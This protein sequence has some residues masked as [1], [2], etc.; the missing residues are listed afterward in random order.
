MRGSA[1]SWSSPA[2]PAKNEYASMNRSAIMSGSA[3]RGRSTASTA[4]SRSTLRISR[5]GMIYLD[6]RCLSGPVQQ[7]RAAICVVLKQTLLP[8]FFSGA[9]WDLPQVPD[10]LRR[11]CQEENTQRKGKCCQADRSPA[12]RLSLSQIKSDGRKFAV[13]LLRVLAVLCHICLCFRKKKIKD[14]IRE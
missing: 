12:V 6:Q 1:S 7:M 8:F 10:D 4:R 5:L 13:A 3:L 14:A 11:L 9:W 2:L